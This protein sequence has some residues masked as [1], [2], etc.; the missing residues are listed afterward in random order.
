V[1]DAAI[2]A[3]AGHLV[4]T[5]VLRAGSTQLA[6]AA[7]HKATEQAIT[8]SNVP[9]TFLRNS[10]CTENYTAPIPS[11]LARGATVAAAGGALTSAA[12]RADYA[13]ACITALTPDS[14]R[15]A[16]SELAGPPFTMRDVAGAVS[17]ATGTRL[18]YRN[19]SPGGR[20]DML[21]ATGGSGITQP[22]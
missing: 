22:A 10:F 5:S 15:N 8:Q 6:I 13:A 20:R 9:V 21:I 19:F 2:A 14:H 3:G 4:Y 16:A 1:V 18:E 12:S 17:R 7:E 11:Y